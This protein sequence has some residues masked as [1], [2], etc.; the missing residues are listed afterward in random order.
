MPCPACTSASTT[1]FF[2]VA[3]APVFCNILCDSRDQALKTPRGQIKLAYCNACGLVFNEAFDESLVKYEGQYE[4]ALHFSAHFRQYAEELAAELIKSY[5][6]RNKRIVELGCGDGSFLSALCRL[7]QNKGFGF[8]PAFDPARAGKLDPNVTI[9]QQLYGPETAG[10][11]ADFVCC[12]HVLEH[13][14]SQAL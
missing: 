3:R 6:L 4:N 9:K 12:R 10:E 14:F 13:I 7:G 1:A 8:D 5:G 11:P 2:H